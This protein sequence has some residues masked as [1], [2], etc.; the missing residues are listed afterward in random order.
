MATR[1]D[2]RRAAG[3]APASGAERVE[4]DQQLEDLA[5]LRAR[6]EHAHVELLALR[7]ERVALQALLVQLEAMLVQVRREAGQHAQIV[8]R[9]A[10][11]LTAERRRGDALT[12]H[13]VRL[14]RLLREARPG[15]GASG[16]A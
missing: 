11:A 7:R 5:A 8:R 2:E 9:L 13:L 12:S 3:S 14:Q 4:R 10:S 16:A 15:R 6:Y 1:R